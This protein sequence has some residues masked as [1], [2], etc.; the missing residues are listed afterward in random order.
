MTLED[1]SAA[2]SPTPTASSAPWCL[3]GTGGL[4]YVL[5]LQRPRQDWMYRRLLLNSPS[6]Y[7]VVL[8]V[9]ALEGQR[10]P[11]SD[12]SVNVCPMRHGRSSPCM[13]LGGPLRLVGACAAGVLDQPPP[14]V[15][16]W[17]DLGRLPRLQH[18]VVEADELIPERHM[19]D[20]P[21]TQY[22]VED[23]DD[24]RTHTEHKSAR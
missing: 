1:P 15:V 21:V 14:S 13:H 2:G 8:R 19:I 24:H 5:D 4:D 9:W 18:G 11:D 10:N 12:N 7:R 3:P 23:K 17:P 20:E 22:Q 16:H 6:G